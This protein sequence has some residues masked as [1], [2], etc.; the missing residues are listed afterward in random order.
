MNNNNNVIDVFNNN[1]YVIPIYQRNYAWGKCEIDQLL[2]DIS[3]FI[4]NNEE[5]YLGTLV[6]KKNNANKYEVIDGQQRLTTLFLLL[7]FLEIKGSVNENSLSFEAR[8]ISNDTLKKI[9]D[10]KT[11][12]GISNKEGQMQKGISVS[13]AHGLRYIADFFENKDEDY[14]NS[15][16][17]TLKRIN[18][19]RVNIPDN[20]N[21]NKYFEIMNT[22]G[23]QLELHEI[24]KANICK[25][26]ENKKMRTLATTIWDACSQM[27]TYVQMNFST[28][29]RTDL[30][31][32]EW[33]SFKIK[34]ESELFNINVVEQ[35]DNKFTI[36]DI[37][38]DIIYEK[39][40]L[41]DEQNSKK[42]SN[43][44]QQRFESV[45]SF[46]QFLLIV[47]EILTIDN[48]EDD[49][50]LDDK[51]FL[52]LLKRY[53]EDENKAKKFIYNLL[54]YRFLFD[55]YIVKRE[56]YKEYK[57]EGKWSLK[58]LK[59]YNQGKVNYVNT[60]DQKDI[61]G[62]VDDKTKTL[63]VLE[64]GLRITYTSPKTMHWISKALNC[65]KNNEIK[66]TDLQEVLELYCAE[67]AKATYLKQGFEIERIVFTYIDYLLY[68]QQNNSNFEFQFRNSIEH[69]YPQNPPADWQ[70]DS[71][72][73]LDSEKY[74]SCL[75]SIGNLAL[76]TV[77]Q[78]SHFSNVMPHD[79]IQ[80]TDSNGAY[81]T[82]KNL[83]LKAMQELMKDDK[84]TPSKVEEHGEAII[85][86]LK[87]DF[88]S[89]GII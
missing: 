60:F 59:K 37:I 40:E 87:N 33:D 29:L 38:E 2:E 75:N 11:Y 13:I 71:W 4:N 7:S 80:F 67:K 50:S 8:D 89:K 61:D 66:Q 82:D 46:A 62:D 68:K 44:E 77:S 26:I 81:V 85:E 73:N 31:D 79:K 57:T 54:K 84:W 55:K 17:E 19:L 14:I 65:E 30:F 43:E 51:N 34:D 45:V 22:R 48:E 16:K 88:K 23:E 41:Q 20:T 32:K 42:K 12:E 15:F 78:N 72:K 1:Q 39:I 36:E 28:E 35:T 25:K 74:N 56:Y 24:A 76:L 5:Y 49:S 53:S 83:K 10:F 47:N 6:V 86:L 58:S 70:Y 18:L 21:L 69:F 64:S 63:R 9:C 52:D 3:S 27:D